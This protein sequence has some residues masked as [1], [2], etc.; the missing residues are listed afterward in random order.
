MIFLFSLIPATGLVILGYFV[1]Y[2][3]MRAEG[4]VKRFGKY[5]GVW[6][7]FLATASILGG[8]FASTVDIPGPMGYIGQHMERMQKMEEQ[9]LEI[10]RDIKRN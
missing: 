5:L 10:L 7:F 4:G 2:T 3:A 9:Q 8:L 6:I 1:I